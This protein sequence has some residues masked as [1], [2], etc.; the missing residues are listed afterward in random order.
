MSNLHVIRLPEGTLS[1]Q[2]SP[3]GFTRPPLPPPGDSPVVHGGQCP[4][5]AGEGSSC[6]PRDSDQQGMPIPFYHPV[7]SSSNPGSLARLLRILSFPP[8]LWLRAPLP[9]LLHLGKRRLCVLL[10]NPCTSACVKLL[11]GEKEPGSLSSGTRK[12]VNRQIN[13]HV[14]LYT[15]PPK[16]IKL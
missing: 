11:S 3:T 10:S 4:P 7:A 14:R 5:L 12:S 16:Y 6:F 9:F 15:L 8:S 1:V 2:Q 13:T